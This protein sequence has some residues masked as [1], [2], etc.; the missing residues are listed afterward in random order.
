MK[1]IFLIAL[2]QLGPEGGRKPEHRTA[3]IARPAPPDT[4][5]ANPPP[6]EI[7]GGAWKM[8]GGCKHLLSRAPVDVSVEDTPDGA[9]LR[10]R[11][12]DPRI[13]RQIARQASAC[14]RGGGGQGHDDHG[15][16]GD[17]GEGDRKRGRKD[18]RHGHDEEKDD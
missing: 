9:V 5:P 18:K 3:P 2:M 17:D 4:S 13:A 8:Q 16:E 7:A 14:L 10:F 11:G 12:T 1:L 15:D 6:D